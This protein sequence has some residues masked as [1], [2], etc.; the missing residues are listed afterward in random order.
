MKTEQEQPEQV[1]PDGINFSQQSPDNVRDNRVAGVEC[2]LQNR[3]APRLRFIALFC[4]L[5]R[6][7]RRFVVDVAGKFLRERNDFRIPVCFALFDCG[8]YPS[9]CLHVKGLYWLCIES[10]FKLRQDSQSHF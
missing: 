2:P 7:W 5:L 9:R 6:W 4:D 1:E 8:K 10:L 3:S